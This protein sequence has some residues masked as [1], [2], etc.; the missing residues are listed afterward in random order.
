MDQNVVFIIIG[1]SALIVGL[2]AGRLFF[3]KNT[4]KQVEEAEQQAQN[5][6]KEAELRAE[7]VKKK[8][9]WKRKNALYS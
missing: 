6:L 7:T 9:N 8:N 3:A 4:K 1:V 2:I 5:I